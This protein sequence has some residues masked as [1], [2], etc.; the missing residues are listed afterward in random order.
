MKWYWWALIALVVIVA[1]VMGWN[2]YQKS[3]MVVP[4]GSAA[5]NG[6]NGSTTVSVDTAPNGAKS[7]S[8][9]KA[10]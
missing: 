8:I 3:K 7:V 5:M 1:I 2:A 4:N 10:A 6:T 9:K